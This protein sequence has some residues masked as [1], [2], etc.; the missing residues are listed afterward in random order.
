MYMK[1]I[2]QSIVPLSAVIL[3]GT[4]LFLVFP[5]CGKK[6]KTSI[7]DPDHHDYTAPVIID[8]SISGNDTLYTDTCDVVWQGNSDEC[9]FRYRL[10]TTETWSNW[11]NTASMHEILA[12]G[13]YQLQVSVRYGKWTD[14]TITTVPLTVL[15]LIKPA[16]YLYPQKQIVTDSQPNATYTV[17]CLGLDSCNVIDIAFSG[18]T[19]HSATPLGALISTG[20]VLVSDTLVTVF[21]LDSVNTAYIQG[22]MSF[23]T[24]T[25]VPSSVI[26]TSH[27]S[28]SVSRARNVG[29]TQDT[30][31][32]G[33]TK[34]GFIIKQ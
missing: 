27:V 19:V 13:S 16:L 4:M 6:S 12:D 23:L 32:I 24:V 7:F 31:Y 3:C 33:E 29:I 20:Q 15:T 34:G 2:K 25:L 8:I 26:D 9:Q 11:S 18:A 21:L 1:T 30:V 17:K 22:D 28:I 5:G 10:D 14:T